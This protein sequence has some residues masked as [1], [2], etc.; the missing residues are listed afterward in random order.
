MTLNDLGDNVAYSY[1]HENLLTGTVDGNGWVV[2]NGSTMKQDDGSP[3]TFHLTTTTS[4][5]DFIYSPPFT[6]K[7]DTNYFLTFN[8]LRSTTKITVDVFV[9]AYGDTK[10]ANDQV[11]SSAYIAFQHRYVQEIGITDTSIG[12]TFTLPQ[13]SVE[14]QYQLR[15]DNNGAADNTL[16]YVD[17]DSLML[18]EGIYA[19]WAPATGE[20]HIGSGIMKP[21]RRNLTNEIKYIRTPSSIEEDSSHPDGIGYMDVDKSQNLWL[22]YYNEYSP[23]QSGIS[24]FSDSTKSYYLHANVCG[25]SDS[26]ITS[27]SIR[28]AIRYASRGGFI[29]EIWVDD[30]NYLTNKYHWVSLGGS[31][32]IPRGCRIA[33]LGMLTNGA[34]SAGTGSPD[35]NEDSSL[36]FTNT[37][38]LDYSD[39]SDVSY[40]K[41]NNVLAQNST[42]SDS[43]SRIVENTFYVIPA[44]DSGIKETV[45]NFDSMTSTIMS[46]GYTIYELDA[47]FASMYSDTVNLNTAHI[48]FL[49]TFVNNKLNNTY[50]AC[51]IANRTRGSIT[52]FRFEQ[53]DPDSILTSL[54][55]SVAGPQ[56][57][58]LVSIKPDTSLVDNKFLS[59]AWSH[60]R[61]R[62]DIARKRTIRHFDITNEILDGSI[63][64]RMDEGNF[65]GVYLGDTFNLPFYHTTSDGSMLVDYLNFEVVDIDKYYGVE[66]NTGTSKT[67]HHI[68]CLQT[69]PIP[70]TWFSGTGVSSSLYT[71]TY[72]STGGYANS[73]YVKKVEALYLTW[74]TTMHTPHKQFNEQDN[75]LEDSYDSYVKPYLLT[76]TINVSNSVGIITDTSGSTTTYRLGDIGRTSI[77]AN[78]FLPSFEEL[79]CVTHKEEDESS[80]F[81]IATINNTMSNLSDTAN[82][83]D[84]DHI[85]NRAWV[86]NIVADG[87]SRYVRNMNNNVG[88]NDHLPMPDAYL[89]DRGE[90]S[91]YLDVSSSTEFCGICPVIVL[92][93]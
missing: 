90:I 76:T 13:S 9:L 1:E 85:A 30:P 61:P 7:H 81:S 36:Y 59:R 55:M 27:N 66:S 2:T 31:I 23:L 25:Y 16:T 51:G 24:E 84:L 68:V 56:P 88:G 32:S 78:S 83:G 73:N 29:N 18:C 75:K 49:A 38:L 62:S 28:L 40:V 72:P 43:Y 14:G 57:E 65:D 15:F 47:D 82:Y 22:G 21:L 39:A 67:K 41:L 58:F 10:T 79:G 12:L 20:T 34:I 19:A 60:L 48:T 93:Y 33:E 86:A 3:A 45:L 50:I 42:K 64:A 53:V 77:T 52:T 54:Y 89:V 26:I 46:S 4:T 91:Q 17:I 8:A 5:E 70:S 63:F 80:A 37:E 74:L 71:S 35:A 69:N 44:A 92:G 87:S 11:S 6:L